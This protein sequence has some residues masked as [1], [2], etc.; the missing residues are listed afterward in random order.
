MEKWLTLG[1]IKKETQECYN[2]KI[3]EHLARDYRKPKM[4][5]GLQK[6]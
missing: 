2:Y 5:L 4:G 1:N 6:K 3:K